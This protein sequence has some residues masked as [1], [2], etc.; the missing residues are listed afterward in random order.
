VCTRGSNRG[1]ARGRSTSPLGVTV[2]AFA[3][4]D[5][6]Y[7]DSRPGV[8]VRASVTLLGSLQHGRISRPGLRWRPNHNFGAADGRAFYIGQVEFDSADAIE[9]G[10]S[11]S[12]LIHFIDGPG[13]RENLQPGRA[14]RIQ[15]GPTL[16]GT[17]T[18]TEV[19]GD[20]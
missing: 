17:A 11:R 2:S 5:L 6:M 13:L 7:F 12:V 19:L 20:P 10:E 15:E 14:W 18:V 4:H 9:P 1:S 16:V 8:R 3:F